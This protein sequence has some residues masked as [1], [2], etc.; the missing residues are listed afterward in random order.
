MSQQSRPTISMSYTNDLRATTENDDACY[1][2]MAE[3]LWKLAASDRNCG[4]R[5]LVNKYSPLRKHNSFL[6]LH[7]VIT[8]RNIA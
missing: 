8:Y 6:Y 5:S 2:K 3:M 1:I 7:T 4:G